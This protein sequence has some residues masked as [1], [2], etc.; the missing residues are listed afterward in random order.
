M[1]GKFINGLFEFQL[2]I[3]P[4]TNP[5]P[6]YQF[7][8]KKSK[9]NYLKIIVF[10]AVLILGFFSFRLG[11]A[12]KKITIEN[13]S[14]WTKIGSILTFDNL[15]QP[16]E[17]KRFPL[18]VKEAER[19]DVLILGIRGKDDPNGG[20]LTD[21]IM[22]LSLNKA[23]GQTA[24]ISIPRDLYA[25]IGGVFSGKINEIYER[26]FL[27]KDVAGF[28]KETFSRISGIYIDNILVFDFQSFE[29]VIDALG[30]I[31]IV[32]EKPFEEKQQWGYVFFLPEG[33][34]RLNGEQALYYA[35]SRYSS[36]DFDRAR[37]QQEIILA[38]KNKI[39]SLEILS[40]PLKINTLVGALGNSIK[41]DLNIWNLGNLIDLIVPLKNADSIPK[42]FIMTSDNIL[43]ETFQ[44]NAYILLPRLNDYK[45]I[46]N[47]FRDIFSK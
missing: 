47:T 46:Q 43:Y 6:D 30:G 31:D 2:S 34:N 23:T 26:G 25:D 21:S 5:Q 13:G 14:W 41:T 29:K 4:L 16:R 3:M 1:R 33:R 20:L 32:L 10:V 35:R 44:N 8:Y 12:Y 38:V 7:F 9:R 11:L 28:A 17:D 22:V 40:N 15:G 42:H 18:P 27:K 39:A 19:L 36:S 37:R 24:V 45:T